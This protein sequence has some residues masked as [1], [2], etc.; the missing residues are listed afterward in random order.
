MFRWAVRKASYVRDR[1]DASSPAARL[2]SRRS[3]AALVWGT[4]LAASAAAHAST[5]PVAAGVSALSPGRVRAIVAIVVALIGAV[6]GGLAVARSRRTGDGNARRRAIVALVLGPLGMVIGGL[7]VV[8]AGGGLGTGHGLGGAVV[9]IVVGLIGM[10]LG[11]LA[12]AR[13]RRTP[14]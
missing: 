8:T 1:I 12:L 7:V 10:A 2:L 14:A 4:G 5:Q 13:C 3:A 6:N 11:G 9:A